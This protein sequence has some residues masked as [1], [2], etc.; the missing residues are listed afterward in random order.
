MQRLN[1]LRISLLASLASCGVNDGQATA[2][3]GSGTDTSSEGTT[4]NEEEVCELGCE[5]ATVLAE[6]IVQCPDGRINRISSGNF[7]DLV[8][9][10]DTAPACAGTEEELNCTSDAECNAAPNGKCIHGERVSGA[11]GVIEICAC[12][13]AC[14][15]DDDCNDSGICLPP[16]VLPGT[17]AWP[18]CQF[19]FACTTNG[20]CGE[21]GECGLGA[22]HD[23]CSYQ[24]GAACRSP[25]DECEAD[26]E[27]AGGMCFPNDDGWLCQYPRCG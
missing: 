1:L 6:G 5:G 14:A 18:S 7:E 20:E 13:Y 19:F 9:A 16:G 15:S 23:G 12:A 21:C 26:V 17:P 22:F 25:A 11:A 10:I 8:M 2:S 4:T 27:C 24:Y 3:M